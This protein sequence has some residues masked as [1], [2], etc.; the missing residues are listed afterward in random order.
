MDILLM[1]CS[2]SVPNYFGPPGVPVKHH[3]EF[4]L[5]AA[6]H[7]VHN[8]GQNECSNLESLARAQK[9]LSGQ[10]IGHP[11]LYNG[12]MIAPPDN[13][14][15][16]FIVWFHTE[17]HREAKDSRAPDLIYRAYQEFFQQ[18]GCSY[19]IIGGAGDLHPSWQDFFQPVFCIPSW[20]REILGFDI[21]K[22]N[23]LWSKHG[24]TDADHLDINSK[25][26]MIHHD[27]EIRQ[28]LQASPDFPDGCHPGTRPHSDLARRILDHLPN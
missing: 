22:S 23:T 1:G 11:A 17:I 15:I 12:V 28:A 20:R 24:I 18:C 2:F 5:Q 7:R 13:L 27:L 4:L 9:Y 26:T 25:L 14:D 10:A 16:R 19:V 21:P 8:C 3:T 6:G